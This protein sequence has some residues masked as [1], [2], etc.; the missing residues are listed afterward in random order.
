M[1]NYTINHKITQN[2]KSMQIYATNAHIYVK[3]QKITQN[4]TKSHK[5]THNNTKYHKIMQ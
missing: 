2:N 4:I 5:I 1:Y 3:L